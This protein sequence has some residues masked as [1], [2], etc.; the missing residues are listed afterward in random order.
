MWVLGRRASVVVVPGLLSTGLIVV[1]HGLSFSLACGIILDQ[2]SNLRLL[3]WQVDSLLLSHQRSS[4]PFFFFFFFFLGYF[5]SDICG[6]LKYFKSL[7][8]IGWSVCGWGSTRW[9]RY[10]WAES[11]GALTGTHRCPCFLL[12]GGRPNPAYTWPQGHS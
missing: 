1:V 5:S 11:A 4:L 8:R 6:T 3:H 10:L 2:E 12:A 7:S 9:Q